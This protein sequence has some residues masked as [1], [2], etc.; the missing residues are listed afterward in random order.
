MNLRDY[1][2]ALNVVR[3]WLKSSDF[4]HCYTKQLIATYELEESFFTALIGLNAIEAHYSQPDV[5]KAGSGLSKV[6]AESIISAIC[7]HSPKTSSSMEELLRQ[8]LTEIIRPI[9]Y[10]A[11][12]DAIAG[13]SPVQATDLP[14]EAPLPEGYFGKKQAAEYLGISES[15]LNVYASTGKIPAIKIRGKNYFEE[16]VLITYKNSLQRKPKHT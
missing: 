2:M 6:S 1:G 11:V 4:A 9:V 7:K 13:K 12:R 16:P 8:L 3:I 5:F 10:D 15:T 14:K